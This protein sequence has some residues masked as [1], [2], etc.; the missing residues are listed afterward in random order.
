[1]ELYDYLALDNEEQ[2]DILWDK[3]EFVDTFVS[4][5]CCYHLF[6]VNKFF[7]EVEI[8]PTNGTIIGKSE[9]IH[10]SKMNK[11]TRSMDL[12]KA[13]WDDFDN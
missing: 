7:I 9:F 10:G 2:W 8:E 4:F 11:Y 12:K 5:D 13:P 3:G 1:M 6:S